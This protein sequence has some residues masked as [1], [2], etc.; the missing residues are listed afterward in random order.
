MGVLSHMALLVAKRFLQL[1][2]LACG[3]TDSPTSAK[4]KYCSS[5]LT[6]SVTGAGWWTAASGDGCPQIFLKA[7]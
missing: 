7:D 5:P 1:R 4:C 3:A 2:V 6:I